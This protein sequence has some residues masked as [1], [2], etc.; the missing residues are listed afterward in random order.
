MRRYV[1]TIFPDAPS[2]KA[3]VRALKDLA[4]SDTIHLHGA[5]AVTK[6]AD[7][8]LIMQVV[9]DD[10]PALTVT[11]ALIGGL[12]GLSMGP[13]GVA[14]FA[15]GGAVFGASAGLTNREAGTSFA[16]QAAEPFA[17]PL[18]AVVAEVS[19]V[20]IDILIARLVACGGTVT[21]EE[22]VSRRPASPK[23]SVSVPDEAR[24]S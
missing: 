22:T 12:A 4:S 5:A 21:Q 17:P 9:A 16:E 1:V 13:L 3:G 15:A 18:E 7:A 14:F 8:K 19:T 10:G 11:G 24:W 20:D 6:G 2:A 23:N